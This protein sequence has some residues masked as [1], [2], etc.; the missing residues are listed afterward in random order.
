MGIDLS[1]FQGIGVF[2]PAYRIM[3]EHDA[4]APGSVD[5]VLC[6]QMVRICDETA[7][8]LYTRSTPTAPEYAA[9]DLPQLEEHARRAVGK[10]ESPEDKV[11]AIAR[12]CAD[13]GLR[14]PTNLDEMRA[15]G[16][17]EQIIERGSDWCTDVAR[18]GCALCQA[19]GL[20]SR[21]VYL[22]D[23]DSAYSG[24]A[25]TEVFRAGR[26]GAVD[27][28]TNVIYRSPDGAPASTW[29]LMNHPDWIRAHGL[30]RPSYYTRPEQ[31][32]GAAVANYFV[33]D[34]CR[35]DYAVSGLN[36]YC[37]SILEMSDKGWPGGL[38]W[39]HGED[40]S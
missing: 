29:E 37:R 30:A 32:R 28:L 38:R 10:A 21:L 24:H 25:I 39:L 9:G 23:T 20:A 15:G 18:V 35:Y 14:A 33:Q 5:R 26:W 36:D 2:G 27:M 6:E 22:A 1:R 16:T 4:H 40:R 7:D 19:A 8:H 13:L 12:F 3:L 17:E 34:R 31:F 11:A